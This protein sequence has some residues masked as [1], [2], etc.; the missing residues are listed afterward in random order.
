VRES[1]AEFFQPTI[2]IRHNKYIWLGT[3]QLFHGLTLIFKENVAG[4]F[5]A[6][7]YKF[8]PTHSTFI[9]ECSEQTWH[10]AGF[11]NQSD[12]ETCNYLEQLFQ[13]ELEHKKLL[14]NNFVK[15]LN[16]PIVKNTHWTHDNIVLLGDALHTA[17]FSIGSGTKLALDDAIALTDS[18]AR[19]NSVAAALADFES[20]RRPRVE[21]YQSAAEASLLMFENMSEEMKLAPLEFA[22][23]MMT[24]SN[25]VTYQ[26]LQQR[27]P[28]FIAQYDAWRSNTNKIA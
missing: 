4:A 26:K 15:W 17:H 9:V 12:V 23:K 5:A 27:D 20:T 10:Q 6:H 7:T 11:D 19:T 21:S 14:S 3:E 25:K 22:Y 28:Q 16:F 1:Y 8:S 13:F 18:V 24:R 2:D